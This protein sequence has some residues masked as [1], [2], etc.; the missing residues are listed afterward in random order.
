MKQFKEK[1]QVKTQ[2]DPFKRGAKPGSPE[3]PKKKHQNRFSPPGDG[4]GA[5]NQGKGAG[6]WGKWAAGTL[7]VAALL[8]AS[9]F[10]GN[11]GDDVSSQEASQINQ[12][13]KAYLAS[14][15]AVQLEA[16]SESETAEAVAA[17]GLSEEKKEQMVAQVKEKKIVLAWVVLWDFAAA[18]GDRVTVKSGS[19]SQEVL[20][21]KQ[22][23][24][25]AV[26]MPAS[27]TIE[28]KGVKDGGGG[29][30][31]GI[32]TGKTFLRIPQLSETQPIKVPVSRI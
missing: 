10:M 6:K 32:V 5:M 20:L 16:V 8:A 21:T 29:I 3:P 19:V 7:V 23:K 9:F 12:E 24:K 17:M 25:V 28:I 22:Y 27:G 30:T 11:K 2:S 14:T 4:G 13:Y 26:P 31:V 1:K 18:D 15:S